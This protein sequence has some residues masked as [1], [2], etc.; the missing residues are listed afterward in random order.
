MKNFPK[1]LLTSLLT[2]ALTFVFVT[3]TIEIFAMS[4][5]HPVIASVLGSDGD[6]DG[7]GGGGGYVPPTPVEK[8]TNPISVKGKTVSVTLAKLAAK[9]QTI[10]RKNAIAVSNA[11]GTVTYTKKS[12]NNYLTINKST[13]NITVKKG[14]KK[15]TYKLVVNVKA[16]GNSSY[17]SRTVQATVTIKIVTASNPISVTTNTVDVAI[18][19]VAE[20]TAV[21]DVSE[22]L[23]IKN[24]KGTVTYVKTIGSEGL[25]VDPATGNITVAEGLA[26]GTYKVEIKVTA[27]GN[28][29]YKSGSRTVVVTIKVKDPAAPEEEAK[30]LDNRLFAVLTAKGSNALSLNWNKVDGAEGYDIFFCSCGKTENQRLVKSLSSGKTSWLRKNLKKGKGYRAQVKAWKKV[31]GKKTYIRLS[32]VVHAF[33]SGV[34]GIY[35]NPKSVSV[36]RSEIL[37][38][39]DGSFKIKASVNKLVKSKMLMPSSHTSKLRYTSG[40]KNIVTVT[41]KGLI[42]AVSKGTCRVYVVAANGARRA[43]LVTVLD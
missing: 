30:K 2:L 20:E 32:P 10:V 18:D 12:G 24:A 25:S 4:S 35:T 33:T 31:D 6:G 23:N 21:V 29:Q 34:S 1:K 8:K 38:A 7:G 22:A 9:S 43:I 27:A 39:H 17:K 41:N 13:G 28:A 16:A 3:G 40:N 37:L 5:G 14:L 42:K 19:E 11:Q 26:A 15:G 36:N